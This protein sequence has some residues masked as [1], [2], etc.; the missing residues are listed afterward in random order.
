[1]RIRLSASSSKGAGT[2]SG[3]KI[4]TKAQGGLEEPTNR[5]FSLGGKT[6]DIANRDDCI[7][8]EQIQVVIDAQL[9]VLQS[10]K[11]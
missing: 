7:S 11:D 3:R 8:Q 10:N 9:N 6:D 5:G 1:M 4:M 2:G